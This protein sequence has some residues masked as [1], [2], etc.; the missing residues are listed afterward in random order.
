VVLW[1]R[2][3]T[4][5]RSQITEPSMP[6]HRRCPL[7]PLRWHRSKTP[8]DPLILRSHPMPHRLLLRQKTSPLSWSQ[9]SASRINNSSQISRERKASDR[10]DRSSASHNSKIE[11]RRKRSRRLR[12][13]PRDLRFRYRLCRLWLMT[14]FGARVDILRRRRGLRWHMCRF[15]RRVTCRF[16]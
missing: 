11:E 14:S 12:N 10:I 3:P 13:S 1:P 6:E 8:M 2:C 5:F 7:A 9:S 16:R 4:I 15:E